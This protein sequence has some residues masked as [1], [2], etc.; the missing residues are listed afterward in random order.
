MDGVEFNAQLPLTT[1]G[2]ETRWAYSTTLSSPHGA[3]QTMDSYVIIIIIT[4]QHANSLVILEGRSPH[5]Q[6]MTG[7]ELF[8]S[9]E[10]RC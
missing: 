2:Q 6:A 4:R 8:C 9:K 3:Q 5:P 7:K 1:L 10:F